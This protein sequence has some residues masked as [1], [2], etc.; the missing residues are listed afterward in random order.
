MSTMNGLSVPETGG[1]VT[2]AEIEFFREHRLS[3]VNIGQHRIEGLKARLQMPEYAMIGRVKKPAGTAVEIRPDRMEF[4]ASVTGSGTVTMP[5]VADAPC[6]NLALSVSAIL[7]GDE[8]TITL[9]SGRSDPD[10][11]GPSI[12]DPA[13]L[14]QLF[15]NGLH[16]YL[17]GTFLYERAAAFIKRA[18][19]VPIEFDRATRKVSSQPCEE[20]DGTRLVLL[21][22]V[23][24]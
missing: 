23:S 9:I 7:P 13:R 12:P 19:L 5:N 2:A 1:I 14:N 16:Y 21:T 3:I 15:A 17:A 11:G 18:F 8:V 22:Q 24:W 20:D 4:M 6:P 10:E